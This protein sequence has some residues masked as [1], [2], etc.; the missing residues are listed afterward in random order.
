M[1]KSK[2]HYAWIIVF[3]TFLSFLAV[4][5][6]RLAF[7]AFVGPWEEDLA[8]DRGTTSLISALSFVIYGVSQ[9]IIGRFVDKYGARLII[10]A[11]TLLVGISFFF[12]T[13]VN[14]PWQ[15][16]VLYAFVSIGVGGASNVAGT[17]L[18]MNWF[19]KKRGLALGILEAGFGFGQMLLVPGSLL[20]IQYVDWR[21]TN[22]LLSIFLIVI[23]FPVVLIFLRNQ[24]T[25]KGLQPVGGLLEEA[26]VTKED[27]PQAK[28]S[29][30]AVLQKRQFWFLMLPFAVC[31]F[32]TTGL[33]DTHLIPLSH[34]HGFSTSVTSAAVSLLAAFN[35]IGILLSGVII[36]YWSSRKLLVFLYITRALSIVILVY[37]HNPLLLLIFAALFG[38]VD[39]ATVAPTQLLAAEYFKKYSIGFIVGCLSLSHQVGSALGAYVPGYFYNLSG[40]YN[41]SLYISIVILVAASLMNFL[42]PEPDKVKTAKTVESVELPS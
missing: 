38:L 35:I 16:F 10:S 20:L 37:S 30:G 42:L 32:T 5:G 12:I 9:P 8:M 27:K 25:E 1:K 7:G 29:I 3:V 23:V 36:D 6:G 22:L 14:Q 40:N 18:V 39:F 24:P 21:M 28:L 19:N 34:N 2:F 15:L 33:M 41:I 31:G 26:Q 11:S 4:Q 13:F 17:V